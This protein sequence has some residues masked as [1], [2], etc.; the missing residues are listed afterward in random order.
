LGGLMF[1]E[2]RDLIDK[3]DRANRL[4]VESDL[5]L[6]F[7][8]EGRL[9]GAGE[10]SRIT[11]ARMKNP[12]SKEDREWRK[13]ATFT[14]HDLDKT[15]EGSDSMSVFS[16]ADLPDMEMLDQDK[17]QKELKKK[18]KTLPSVPD[19]EDEE[20]MGKTFGER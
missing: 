2:F 8:K 17:V 9:Y 16:I 18:G 15:A 11:Y 19:D 13:D 1:S 20:P 12:E 4:M 7:R 10:T 14:A 5:C 3:W 6:F